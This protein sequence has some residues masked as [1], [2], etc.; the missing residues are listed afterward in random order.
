MGV[1]GFGRIGRLVT[2]IV[3]EDETD[4]MKHVAAV[5]AKQYSSSKNIFQK[6]FE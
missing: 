6:L 4:L 5:D 1:N 2:R 3:M